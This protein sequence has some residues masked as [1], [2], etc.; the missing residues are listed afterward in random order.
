MRVGI[1]SY[2]MLFERD[3]GLQVQVRETVR[4]LNRLPAEHAVHAELADPVH[5]RLAHFDVVHVFAAINGNHR[6][7]EAATEAGVPTVLSPLVSP[8]WTRT[9]GVRARVADRVLGNLTRWNVQSSYAQMRSALEQANRVIALGDEERR[10]I[11]EAF[12]VDV[13]KVRV[14]PN[15]ISHQFFG[16]APS[17]FRERT[18][19]RGPF[20]LM[21][22]SISPYKNQLGLA[23]ALSE[24]ALPLVLIGEAQERD[25]S[26]LQAL[27]KV[28]GVVCMGPI[29]HTDPLLASA[30]AAASVFALPSQ[31]EV[32]PLSVME[33][34]AAG[35]PVVMTDQSA[36]H[37]VDDAFAI[38]RVRWNDN[39]AQQRAVLAHVEAP[40]ERARVRA[41]VQDYT[42][43]RVA[44]QL[45]GLYRELLGQPA[46]S[47]RA[48]DAV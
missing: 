37:L 6:I 29:A 43:E 19:L 28:R 38:T 2:P 27:R 18:G 24:L 42:W 34:L 32:A 3:G 20:V 12:L 7:I 47:E 26:Y 44:M 11:E 10:A 21:V 14:L 23:E 16:A 48:R 40:P 31:G 36:L 33:A 46:A 1:L 8:G 22:A 30:Y 45:A 25:Q 9:T 17:L 5:M 4:A 35:T 13:T 41:L 39:A 15:G